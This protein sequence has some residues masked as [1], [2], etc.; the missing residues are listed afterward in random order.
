MSF[1]SQDRRADEKLGEIL[2]RVGSVRLRL[3]S[4][5]IQHAVFYTLAIMIACGA[6]IF[7]ARTSFRR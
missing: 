4:L 3:N 5:A 6:A 2:G 1:S 7:V